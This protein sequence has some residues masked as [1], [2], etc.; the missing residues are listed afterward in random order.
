M[1]YFKQHDPD[2]DPLPS[3]W[4]GNSQTG[5]SQRPKRLPTPTDGARFSLSHPI[6]EGRGEGVPIHSTKTKEFKLKSARHKA[7]NSV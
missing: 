5:L 1:A 7:V 3:D 4:S 2:P 6:G